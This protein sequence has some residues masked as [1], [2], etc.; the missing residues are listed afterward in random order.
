MKNRKSQK[1]VGLIEVLITAVVFAVG[2]A[3]ILQLQSKF[4]RGSSAANARSIGMSIAQEKIDDLR[5][6]QVTDSSDADIFDF[7]AIVDDNGGNCT[8]QNNDDACILS[9]PSGNETKGNITYTRN[10][11]VVN[12][13]DNAGALTTTANAGGIVQKR[14]TV[15]IN[16]TDTD[17]SSSSASLDTI[18]SKISGASASGIV[19]NNAGGSGEAPEVPYTPSVDTNVTPINVGSAS[20]RETLVPSSTTVDGYSRT[21]FIANTYSD[22]GSSILLRQEEFQTV[23]CDCRF[24]GLSD[25]DNQTYTSAHAE[26]SDTDNTYVDIEGELVSNKVQGC[27]QGGG[28]NCSANPDPLCETCCQDHH[29]ISSVDR[30]YDPF[31][32]SDSGQ[33]SYDYTAIDNSTDPSSGEDH[34]HYNGTTAVTTGQYLESCRFKRINGYWRLYQD[35]HLVELTV[36]PLSDLQ[37]TTTKASYASYVNTIIDQYLDE[38]K[39]KGEHLTSPPTKPAALD[40]T[41]SNNYIDLASVGVKTNLS[42]RAIYLDFIDS[43]HLTEVKSRKSASTDYLLHLPFYEV[44]I[45]PQTG[46]VSA[47]DSIVK[48]GP[49]DGPG[50][51]DDLTSGELHAI[52]I[53]STAQDVTGSVKRS[54][55]GIV[56]LTTAVDTNVV[57]G[58]VNS[59]HTK[60][61]DFVKVCSGASCGSSTD[62]TLPWGGSITSGS[63]STAF[64]TATVSFGSSCTS[65]SRSC[66]NTV[67]SGSYQFDT[68][69][70]LAADS[71]TTPWSTTVAHTGTVT[72]YL[73]ATDDPCVSE[74]RTCTDGSL[75][76]TYS[77][78]ACS[79]ANDCTTPW[80]TT[81][82]NG[83]STTAYENAIVVSGSCVSESQ[84]CTNGALSGSYT[85]SSCSVGCTLGATT[86]ADGGSITAY[87]ALSVDS[88]AVC[89]DIDETRNCSSGALS[90]TF[91]YDS[92][93]VSSTCTSTVTG[94]AQNNKTYT[95]T[96]DGGSSIV[97]GLTGNG[98]TLSYNC[99]TQ[100]AVNVSG[101]SIVVTETDNS[102]TTHTIVSP[103]ICGSVVSDFR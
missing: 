21:K 82:T 86:V 13:Y 47:D 70:V 50:S 94:T 43:T 37:S 68:C 84:L 100:P 44:E 81:V 62:C 59:D 3:A 31:R 65:E 17:S 2:I 34:K 99:P 23:A 45:A 14:V 25:D 53:N 5:G 49:Y 61:S 40:H 77:N 52:A 71:C 28:N 56:S 79:A 95:M 27:V 12:Y 19:A 97:C 103:N 8:E 15:T 39:V 67:L 78:S 102:P 35:W 83:A 60:I 36:L 58:A 93:S 9:I 66:L 90:G 6:F 96:V 7:S 4:F 87:S 63:S 80:A 85:N 91:A 55:S 98:N 48:V 88:P 16:W 69:N 75:S 20:K 42:S 41:T 76:G 22:G 24:N 89:A 64:S 46:W 38:S 92:C 33:A 32:S 51:S 101:T 18:I 29:D 11:A 26:W 57:D 72:A 74:V 73:N 1:G 54:N 10:W 30:K